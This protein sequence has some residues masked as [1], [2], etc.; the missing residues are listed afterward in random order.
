MFL[1]GQII[2]FL[3]NDE[4]KVGYVRKQE[5]DRLQ[6]L[7][8]RG[9]HVSINGDRVVVTHRKSSEDVFQSH[10]K[11]LSQNVQQRQS[12]VDVELL[13]ESLSG[14]QREFT[15]A[16]LAH[17]FFSE[18]SPEAVSAVFRT[19][20]SDTLFFRRKGLQ[21]MPRTVDQVGTE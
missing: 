11:E 19:L 14:V 16:E 9:R 7:D 5:H 6:I 4:L 12:E 1:E 17:L 2:E 21:F 3:D 15:S 10:A 8:P 13:W 18:T 20:L